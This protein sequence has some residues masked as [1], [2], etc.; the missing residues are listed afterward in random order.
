MPASSFEMV[1]E[2]KYW[3]TNLTTQKFVQEE[4]KSGLK[5]ENGKKR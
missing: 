3:E 4:I 1:G 5:S 2:V